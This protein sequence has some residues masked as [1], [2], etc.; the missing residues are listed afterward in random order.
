MWVKHKVVRA[1]VELNNG[2]NY[3]AE[4]LDKMVKDAGGKTSIP[5]FL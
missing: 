5:Y 3:Y 2:G 1:D 4:D